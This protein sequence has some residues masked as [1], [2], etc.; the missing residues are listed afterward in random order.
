MYEHGAFIQHMHS[1]KLREFVPA[2]F[3]NALG[4]VE[5]ERVI[6]RRSLKFLG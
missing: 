3:I 5:D 2:D 6:Y 4:R 1:V